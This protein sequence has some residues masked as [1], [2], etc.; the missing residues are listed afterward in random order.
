[1]ESY[2]KMELRESK[3][4]NHKFNSKILQINISVHPI[5]IILNYKYKSI[6]LGLI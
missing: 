6:Y 2:I 3:L 5:S 4:F 1:M